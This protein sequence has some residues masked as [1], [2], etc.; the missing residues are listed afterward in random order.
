MTRAR[1]LAE[2]ASFAAVGTGAVERAPEDKLR[3]IVSV[4]DFGAVGDGVTDDY[5]AIIAARDAARTANATLRFLSGKYVFGTTLD[6]GA[7]FDVIEF[8]SEVELIYTG[9][10]GAG[11]AAITFNGVPYAASAGGGAAGG[12]FGIGAAPRIN[13]GGAEYGVD[14]TAWHHGTLKA[15]VWNCTVGFRV[16]HCVLSRFD[17][18]ATVNRPAYVS[19]GTQPTNGLIIDSYDWGGTIGLLKTTACD[20]YIIIEGV[21]GYGVYNITGDNCRFT[22]TSEGNSGTGGGVRDGIDARR[23]RYSLFCEAN[24][25]YDFLLEGDGGLLDASVADSAGGIRITGARYVVSNTRAKK[26]ELVSG[27][28]ANTLRNVGIIEQPAGGGGLI[29]GGTGT[30]LDHIFVEHVSGSVA[31]PNEMLK[32]KLKKL[33]QIAITNA[34]VADTRVVIT[35]ASHGLDWGD[36]VLI[37]GVGGMTQLNGNT[38]TV[39]PLTADTFRLMNTTSTAYIDGSTFTAYTSGGAWTIAAFTNAWIA[40][41][42]AT[43]GTPG[44]YRNEDGEVQLAGTISSGTASAVAFTLPAG[45]RP[46]ATKRFACPEYSTGG[47]VSVDVDSAGQVI[48]HSTATTSLNGI[49][50]PTW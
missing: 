40:Y 37:D 48:V 33:G 12:V 18:S 30:I 24:G 39:E 23:S 28:N 20:F 14:I 26:L 10:T 36:S 9:V 47:A 22:G 43:Y 8:D 25:T 21:S 45:F 17:V 31:R 46:T 34:V 5:T 11:T 6:F 7:S 35:S 32:P 27:S 16:R 2:L 38:Y 4:K 29:N 42:P 19:G 44:F 13:A 49:R 15:E 3:E 1:N 41:T 50:F